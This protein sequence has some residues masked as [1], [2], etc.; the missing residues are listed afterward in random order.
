MSSKRW[1]IYLLKSLTSNYVYVGFTN[2]PLKRLRKHNGIVGGGAK[3]TKFRRPHQLMM[4]LTA[5]P[6]WF[7][8]PTALR[9]EWMIPFLKRQL[10]KRRR[11]SVKRRKTNRY[12]LDGNRSFKLSPKSKNFSLIQHINAILWMFHQYHWLFHRKKDW[13]TT[14]DWKANNLFPHQTVAHSVPSIKWRIHPEL[15]DV[16]D[17]Q[18]CKEWA[19]E[20][21]NL[22]I[23]KSV[24]YFSNNKVQKIGNIIR[25]ANIVKK[26]K[27]K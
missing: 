20:K 5:S 23:T 2:D 14:T 4:Y 12:E 7:D 21:S 27:K 25:D 22:W 26:R 13:Q 11:K 8:K 16:I 19:S 18:Q 1:Y 24:K 3:K 6:K 15:K 10:Y 9:M 17:I